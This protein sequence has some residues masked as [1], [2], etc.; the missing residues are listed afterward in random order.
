[1]NSATKCLR[2]TQAERGRYAI[3]VLVLASVVAYW[4][5]IGLAYAGMNRLYGGSIAGIAWGVIVSWLDL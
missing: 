3:G 4:I 2:R 5:A 1:M